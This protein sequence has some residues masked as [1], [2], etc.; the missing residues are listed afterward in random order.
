MNKYIKIQWYDT[1]TTQETLE[2]QGE[3]YPFIPVT[4]LM[5]WHRNLDIVRISLDLTWP[6]LTLAWLDYA[7][8]LADSVQVLSPAAQQG[9]AKRTKEELDQCNKWLKDNGW[10]Q[11]LPQPVFLAGVF[12]STCITVSRCEQWFSN[13]GDINGLTFKNLS[14]QLVEKNKSW[15][16]SWGFQKSKNEAGSQATAIAPWW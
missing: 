16:S 12:C 2:E 10:M 3:M 15:K 13:K 1:L 9:K 7:L 4:Q 14:E 8:W 6:D 11:N 5:R